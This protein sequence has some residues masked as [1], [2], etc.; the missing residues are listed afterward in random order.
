MTF[1]WTQENCVELLRIT[2]KLQEQTHKVQESLLDLLTTR[3][4]SQTTPKPILDFEE[5]PMLMAGSCGEGEY[6]HC[7]VATMTSLFCLF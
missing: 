1:L 3:E 4:L 7:Q 2:H 5:G 6:I